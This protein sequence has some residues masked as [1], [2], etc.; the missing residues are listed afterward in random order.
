MYIGKKFKID[1]AHYLPDHPG[2]CKETHGHTW[3]IIVEVTGDVDPKTGMVMD[4][5]DLSECV[6][7]VIDKL[8]HNFLNKI[9]PI[10]TCEN[11]SQYFRDKIQ[12]GLPSDVYI[13]S[14]QVQEGDGGYAV[15]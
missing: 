4:L 9:V 13:R 5:H 15:C 14:V 7:L 8:D 6:H 2:K 1:A 12:L 11:L 10:P 3:T